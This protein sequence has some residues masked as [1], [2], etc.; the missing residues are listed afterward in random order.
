MFFLAGFVRLLLVDYSKKCGVFF[1]RQWGIGARR[2]SCSSFWASMS[3]RVPSRH[4]GRD[5]TVDDRVVGRVRS[6]TGRATHD[7]IGAKIGKGRGR[8]FQ[9]YEE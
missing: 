9:I 6:P 1:L 4:R 3:Q 8:V 5:G 2:R 7:D